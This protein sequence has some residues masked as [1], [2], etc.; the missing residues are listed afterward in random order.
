[1]Q[2][3]GRSLS[4]LTLLLIPGLGHPTRGDDAPKVENKPLPDIDAV[5]SRWHERMASVTT[6]EV[7]FR[8]KEEQSV[9]EARESVGRLVLESP[10]FALFESEYAKLDEEGKPSTFRSRMTWKEGEFLLF[11]YDRNH[12]GRYQRRKEHARPPQFLTLPFLFQTT[13]EQAREKY[14]WSVLGERDGRVWLQATRRGEKKGT[15]DPDRWSIILNR[16]SNLPEKFFLEETKDRE[17]QTFEIVDLKL[18]QP[19]DPELKN[20]CL[21]AW[22]IDEA[23][24]WLAWLISQ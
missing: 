7:K 4:F 9:W 17:R 3:I 22:W 13:V 21:D 6:L 12:V 24:K 10:G 8:R 18:N 11:D 16:G 15:F 5:L 20:P 2:R 1:M 19:I 14:D 23:P